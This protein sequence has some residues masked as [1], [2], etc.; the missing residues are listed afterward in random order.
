MQILRKRNRALG[1]R[2]R[3]A[4]RSRQPDKAAEIRAAPPP[5]DQ[6]ALESWICTAQYYADFISGFAMLAAPLNELRRNNVE[7]TWT[8]KRQKAFDNIK[9][10][11][12]AQ[13]LRV[14]FEESRQLILA[15]DA[16]PYGIGAV[17]MQKHDDGIEHMVTCASRTLSATERRYPQI[18]KEALIIV[19]GY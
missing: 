16:S 19:F 11:L 15:T 14:H 9:A 5:K 18:E 6:Q 4:R 3:Q 10:A 2:I 1:A 7:F 13:T 8:P 12:A 17:L